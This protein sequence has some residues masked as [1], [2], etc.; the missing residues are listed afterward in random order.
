[1]GIMPVWQ[2]GVNRSSETMRGVYIYIYIWQFIIDNY[3][4]LQCYN[5]LGSSWPN[6]EE[7]P[8]WEWS[9]MRSSWPRDLSTCLSLSR[10]RLQSEDHH[11]GWKQGKAGN[12]GKW[13]NSAHRLWSVR[14]S[15]QSCRSRLSSRSSTNC[16]HKRPGDGAYATPFLPICPCGTQASSLLF[17]SSAPGFPFSLSLQLFLPWLCPV[18]L[19]WLSFA[20]HCRTGALPNPDA[21]LLPRCPG[22]HLG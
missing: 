15:S 3:S 6:L 9:R 19:S 20:G 2:A 8:L 16:S 11:R 12:M 4:L 14:H 17:M 10:C 1:M 5:I 13:Q 18:V 7:S 21:E 22:S